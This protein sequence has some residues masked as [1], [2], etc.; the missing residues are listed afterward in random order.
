ME[1]FWV[2]AQIWLG[3]LGKGGGK[4]PFIHGKELGREGLGEKEGGGIWFKIVTP[5]KKGRKGAKESIL[6]NGLLG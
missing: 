6:S 5:K 1:I 2:S 3:N 4:D